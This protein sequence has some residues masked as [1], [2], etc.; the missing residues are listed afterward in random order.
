MKILLVGEYSRLHN[1]LKEGLQALGHEVTLV[2]CGDYFKQ[3]PVDIKLKRPYTQG[4]SRKIKNVFYRLTGIDLVSVSI[5][6]Q[7][8]KQAEKFKGYDIVQLINE[9]PLGIQPKHEWEV[10]QFLKEHNKKLYLLSCGTD[11]ISVSY[12]Y[13]KKFRYSILSPLFEGKVD[14]KA[15]DPILKYLKPEFVKLH[16]RVMG[17]VEGVIASDLDYHIPM[18][19]HPKYLGL[20]P[21][22]IN[23]E[24]IPYTFPKQRDPIVIFHGINTANYYKKGSDYFEAAL[25]R[26]EKKYGDKVYVI[27][28]AD[29]PYK[30][31]ITK[32]DSAHVVMDQVL[33]FDQGYN[34]LEAMAKGKVVFTGAETEW[35]KHYNLEEDSVAINALPDT[36]AIFKKLEWLIQN[37]E[38]LDIISHNARAFVEQEHDYK[39]IAKYYVKTWREA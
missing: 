16:H 17:V 20:I 23:V 3:F 2:G 26:I 28:T 34:A 32:Y 8:F 21:N 22:P 25:D 36:E 5:R 30:E 6:N 35:L 13:E 29:V 24:K 7:F 9:S 15:F 38:Q 11:Y 14:A 19:E 37:P 10:V 33:G 4:L 1:S 18:V 27:T 39:K 31:Y 12:A